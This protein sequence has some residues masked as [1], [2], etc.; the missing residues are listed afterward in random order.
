MALK[1]KAESNIESLEKLLAETCQAIYEAAK[2]VD[3]VPQYPWVLVRVLPKE[4]EKNLIILPEAQNK[5]VYEGIVLTT[6]KPFRRVFLATQKSTLYPEYRLEGE[7]L[8]SNYQLGD[9]ISF[10][11]FEGQPIPWLDD[12]HY[13]IVREDVD[14]GISPR[15]GTFGKLHYKQDE[16]LRE[17]L[18]ELFK[19]TAM[20]TV[21]GK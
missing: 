16:G 14:Q 9:R 6:W 13:R 5:V 10:M 11:H 2:P 3:F 12:H 7:L 21:S 4:Q 8:K 20:V 19:G 17:A 18:N 1:H 15:C